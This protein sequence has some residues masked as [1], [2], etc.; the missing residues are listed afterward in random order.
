MGQILSIMFSL[1][2]AFCSGS[3]IREPK[4]TDKIFIKDYRHFGSEGGLAMDPDTGV[5]MSDA[6]PRFY[7]MDANLTQFENG[8][9]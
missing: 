3:L 2:F 7:I 1:V 8:T 4:N 5:P 6:R 9:S